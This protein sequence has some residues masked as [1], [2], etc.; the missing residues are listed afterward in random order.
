[1]K[2]EERAERLARAIDE[3]LQGNSPGKLDDSDLSELLRVAKAR[4]DAADM[5]GQVSVQHEGDVWKQLLR[6]L[7][8]RGD[9]SATA[10]QA[11]S[12]LRRSKQTREVGRRRAMDRVDPGSSGQS[13][14]EYRLP[15][16]SHVC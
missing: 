15:N 10:H 7:G 9:A 11:P 4:M 13:P 3:L 12:T 6:R 8:H 16:S 1:M 5:A 2:E 14:I